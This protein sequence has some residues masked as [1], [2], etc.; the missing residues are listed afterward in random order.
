M[1]H[2]TTSKS[3]DVLNVISSTSPANSTFH[4]TPS[5]QSTSSQKQNNN[6][7]AGASEEK[8]SVLKSSPFTGSLFQLSEEYSCMPDRLD[9][10]QLEEDTWSRRRRHSVIDPN[11]CTNDSYCPER[12]LLDRRKSVACF[13]YKNSALKGLADLKIES[14]SQEDE[15]KSSPKVD[16]VLDLIDTN[17]SC[18]PSPKGQS[19]TISSNTKEHDHD[20]KVIEK[21]SL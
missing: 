15:E 16:I 3:G 19:R 21:K 20:D 9:K 11:F 10:N 8:S 7:P 2:G 4:L 6:S 5:A 1:V 13:D 12:S 14:G 18:G 17:G